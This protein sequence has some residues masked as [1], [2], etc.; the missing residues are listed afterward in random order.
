[1]LATRANIAA[2]SLHCGRFTKFQA[3]ISQATKPAMLKALEVVD[4]DGV[5]DVHT[6]EQKNDESDFSFQLHG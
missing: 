3:V 6:V 4:S 2:E 5:N 1:M